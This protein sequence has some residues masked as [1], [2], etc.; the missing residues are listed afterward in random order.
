MSYGLVFQD[1]HDHGDALAAANA[2]RGQTIAQ[3][4]AAKFVQ[5]GDDQ[6][7]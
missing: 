3:A 4:I 7:R 1:F 6:A 2:S 5:D